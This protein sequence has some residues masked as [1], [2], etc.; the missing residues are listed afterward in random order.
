M[1]RVH[2]QK[3][4][5]RQN[6]KLFRQTSEGYG[7]SFRRT[8]NL[9]AEKLGDPSIRSIRLYDLRHFYATVTY[10]KTRDILFVK[11]KMGHKKIETTL[12]YTQLVDFDS[13]DYTVRT[14]STVKEACKRLESGFE[15]VTD[16]DHTK[17]FRKRK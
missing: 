12:R 8:R 9:L 7:K 10:H 15:Y 11:Q 4:K 14:A 1:L 2:V 6:Q 5:L 13:E 3:R 17:I 16:M